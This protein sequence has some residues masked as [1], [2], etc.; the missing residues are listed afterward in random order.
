MRVA[1]VATHH[2][3]YSANL[4]Q[5]LAREHRVL[6]I[7]SAR[8]AARQLAPEAMAALSEVLTLRIV[9]H[10]YAPLQPLIA[11]LCGREVARFAP[12]VVHVQEHPSRAVGMLAARMGGRWP[13]LTTVH[14][15][16]PHSGADARAAAPFIRWNER[17]RALSDRLIVHG[18]RLLAPMAATQA[19]GEARVRVARHG[20]LRFGRLAGPG[21]LTTGDG[22]VFFGRMNRYKGLGT[23]LDANDRWRAAGFRPRIVVAGEGPEIGRWRARIAAAPNIALHDWRVP[24]DALAALVR[25]AAA[26]VLPAWCRIW[27]RPCITRAV[28]QRTARS[29]PPSAWHWP[30]CVIWWSAAFPTPP[31]MTSSV[32]AGRPSRRPSGTEP[33]PVLW[34]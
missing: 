3:E 31:T 33:R 8:N 16:Q 9:P 11:R 27:P 15:P 30:W 20:V 21:H 23:L 4:A 22:L 5:A 34:K 24:Q 17:L 19:D 13:L 28:W 7:L 29:F 1:L 26:A 32:C 14:D 12:D 25:G 6:L 18:E 2:A 10:H